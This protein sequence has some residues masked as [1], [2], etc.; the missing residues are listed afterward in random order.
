MARLYGERWLR[1]PMPFGVR[2][3]GIFSMYKQTQFYEKKV[4]LNELVLILLL[5]LNTWNCLV[6]S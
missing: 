4:L 1:D 5:K 2:C 6:K 3:V